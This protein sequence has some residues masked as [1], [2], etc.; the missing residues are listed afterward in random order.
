MSNVFEFFYSYFGKTNLK[1]KGALN[2]RGRDEEF[3]R[4]LISDSTTIDII[5]T[6]IKF[7]H[8]LIMIFI[9]KG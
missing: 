7:F 1:F 6:I 4:N 9:D 5:D 8:P 2:Y 3:L